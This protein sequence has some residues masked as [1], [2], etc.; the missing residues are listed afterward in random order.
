VR[1]VNFLTILSGFSSKL[2]LFVFFLLSFH[3][4]SFARDLH[5]KFGLGYNSQFQNF[6]Q[7]NG[8]PGVSIKYGLSKDIGANL[9]FGI[10]TSNPG[11][12]VTALKLF[13][14]IFYETNL[15]FHFMLGAGIL[16]AA[17]TAGTASLSGAEFLAGFG[18]EF[19]IPGV[20]SLG[21]TIETGASF[22]NITGSFVLRTI[23]VS[24]LNAGIHFYF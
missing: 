10:A 1:R 12:S 7:S 17:D 8:V 13:K 24:F 18:A 9:I 4:D 5:G 14:N 21:F 19:F 11:N 2:I 3:S 20:E 22:S 16:S 15:N 6:A 23:G